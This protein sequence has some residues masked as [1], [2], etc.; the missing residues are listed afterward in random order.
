MIPE[1][2]TL[3]EEIPKKKNKYLLNFD[4]IDLNY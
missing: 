2:K 3:E 1:L 4:L